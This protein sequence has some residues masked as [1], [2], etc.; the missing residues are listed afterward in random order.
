M[1]IKEWGKTTEW[2]AREAYKSFASDF[3]ADRTITG[4]EK[5]KEINIQLRTYF[6]SE[7]GCQV[8]LTINN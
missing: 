4:W 7:T 2:D 5:Y 1:G 8:V 6:F 3:K